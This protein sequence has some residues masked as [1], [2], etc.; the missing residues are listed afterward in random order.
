ML[1]KLFG[2]KVRAAILETIFSDPDNDYYSRLLEKVTGMDHKAIWKELI[3]LEQNGIVQS[4]RDGK[5]KKY[6]VLAFPGL[7]EL[8]G[9]VLISTDKSP[10]KK[11][12]KKR[13]KK[14]AERPESVKAQLEQLTLI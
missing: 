1:D 9:F 4:Y 14:G 3:Q 13:A 2:S 5:L 11:K 10:V 7:Q 8:R 12:V 6:K